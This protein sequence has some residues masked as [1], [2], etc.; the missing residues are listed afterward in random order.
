MRTAALCLL[1]LTLTS[2]TRGWLQ[3]KANFA[4]QYDQLADQVVG[5]IDPRLARFEGAVEGLQA[6]LDNIP[7]DQEGNVTLD[8]WLYMAGT[9]IGGL[10]GLHFYRNS[11]S[12]RRIEDEIKKSP[13]A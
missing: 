5:S 11:T 13:T 3:E 7:E 1:C 6:G 12:R 4:A 9:T 8:Q 10:F 2:C